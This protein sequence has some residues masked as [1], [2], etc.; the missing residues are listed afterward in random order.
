MGLVLLFVFF[1]SNYVCDTIPSV[2]CDG[3]CRD[4]TPICLIYTYLLRGRILSCTHFQEI[5]NPT[6]PDPRFLCSDLIRI[7]PYPIPHYLIGIKKTIQKEF[8]GNTVSVSFYIIKGIPEVDN[9]FLFLDELS[10]FGISTKA[11]RHCA[12]LGL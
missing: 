2:L 6:N 12:I 9:H 8:C 1:L 11:S 3:D 7:Q 10:L 5:N 4:Y